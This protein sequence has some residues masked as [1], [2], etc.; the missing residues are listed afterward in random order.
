MKLRVTILFLLAFVLTTEAQP[1]QEKHFPHQVVC[2]GSNEVHRNFVPSP[3]RYRLKSAEATQATINVTYIGFSA[4][5]REAFAYAVSI[6]EG[7]IQS[8]V[9]INM[10]ARWSTLDEGVLGSCGPSDYLENFASAPLADH[11]YP[12]AL[13]EK[14]AGMELNASTTADLIAQF[15]SANEDWYFGTDGATPNDKYDFVSVV[16]HEIAHG[17]GF[18]G[19]CYETTSGLGAYGWTEFHPGIFDAYM[20][21]FDGDK[22][23]DQSLFPNLSEALLTEFES[24]YLEFESD[25]ASTKLSG[26]YPRLY[27]PG[28]Y[29]EGSSLYHLNEG[30]YFP[31]NPHS[32]MTPSI[33]RGEAIHDPGSVTLAMLEEMGWRN[34]TLIHTELADTEDSSSP[35]P[36]HLGINADTEIDSS[37]VRVIYTNSDFSSA[38]TLFLAYD[39]ANAQFS[40]TIP[41]PGVGDLR[42]F[43]SSTDVE[44]RVYKLPALAPDNYFELHIGPDNTPPTLQHEALTFILESEQSMSINAVATDNIAIDKVELQYAVN[45]DAFQTVELNRTGDLFSR[46]VNFSG[47]TDG[48]SIRYRLIATDASSQQLSTTL[49]ADGYFR[50]IVDG[51]YSPVTSYSNDFNSTST[52]F[53]LDEFYIGTPAGFSSGA[54]NSPHPYP[55]PEVSDQVFNLTAQLKY[56]IVLQEAGTMS[57]SEIVL[58]EPG[59]NGTNY[60]DEDFWDYVVVEGSLNGTDNWLPLADGYDSRA[61]TNWENLFNGAIDGNN[62]TAVGTEDIYIRRDINLLETG[63]FNAGETIFIRFRL[64]SDPFAN[65]WGWAIDNLVIQ[66]NATAVNQAELSPGEL[67][68][69]PNPATDWINIEGNLTSDRGAIRMSLRNGL[70]QLI[71][72]QMLS[73]G[74]RQFQQ[75]IDLKGLSTGVYMLVL[76]FENGEYYTRKVVL[77]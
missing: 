46:T 52:D 77:Q 40:T 54:L 13:A 47:L 43:L 74:S 1:V 58:V 64:F 57:F 56:P 45:T 44:G 19:L 20:I 8:P 62:S 75:Q 59:S 48:D 34:N 31:G 29:D 55:S 72:E 30:S 16:L 22:L 67:I 32:L 39:E 11:Y 2:Y 41:N 33:G 63:N 23:V 14:L 18:T 21:N 38:D 68:F 42:Y 69:Y 76:Q 71:R 25:W 49:P 35:L 27:S 66:D 61:N 36:I 6:W 10:Q 70:G 65:G 53:I 15:N 3:F 17:L 24:G 50:V 5:A 51:L 9:T 4:E 37:L 73:D 12:I 28:T 26:T 7:L 60:G